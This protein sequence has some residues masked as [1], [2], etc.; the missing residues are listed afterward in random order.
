MWPPAAELTERGPRLRVFAIT[1]TA[2]TKD[3]DVGVGHSA[4][5][6]LDA[7]HEL[8]GADALISRLVV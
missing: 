8:L 1:R 5:R 3:L 6:S 4:H 2:P 7:F